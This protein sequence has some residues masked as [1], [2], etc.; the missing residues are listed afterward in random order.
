MPDPGEGSGSLPSPVTV[1]YGYHV[2]CTNVVTRLY[3]GQNVTLSWDLYVLPD[4][5]L[6]NAPKIALVDVVF[7]TNAPTVE[8]T[9]RHAICMREFLCTK[10]K[11]LWHY[12]HSRKTSFKAGVFV[13]SVRSCVLG[14]LSVQ[15]TVRAFLDHGKSAVRYLYS[16]KV[17]LFG[18]APIDWRRSTAWVLSVD[19]TSCFDS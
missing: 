3:E 5:I 19:L 1:N 10:A 8:S 4:P 6:I 18:T 17:R 12:L 2:D 14:W 13:D 11:N 7:P 16:T 9:A 15:A